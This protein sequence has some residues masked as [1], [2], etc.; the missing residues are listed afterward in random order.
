VG[1]RQVTHAEPVEGAQGAQGVPDAVPALRAEQRRDP[2]LAARLLDVVGGAGQHQVARV[3]GDHAVNQ[4]DLFERGG[5]GLV[6]G[7]VARDEHRPELGTDAAGAQARQ[8]GVEPV[9][10][11]ITVDVRRIGPRAAPPLPRQVVVPVQ[12][13]CLG[14]HAADALVHGHHSRSIFAR[15]RRE[16]FY[17]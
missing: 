7:H 14:Q 1:Q 6:A 15:E 8:V 17:S 13:R 5:D 9:R 3:P 10:R 16:A 12:H 4:V 2:A 11:K